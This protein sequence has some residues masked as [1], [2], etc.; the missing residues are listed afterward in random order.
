MNQLSS[1]WI[2][3]SQ[4]A[5][6]TKFSQEYIRKM[7]REGTIVAQKVGHTTL[8]SKESLLKYYQRQQAKKEA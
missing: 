5:E 1:D 6:L 2:S 4:A 8:I 3:T 7:A